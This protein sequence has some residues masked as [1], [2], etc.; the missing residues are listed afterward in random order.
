[1]A[2]RW[3]DSDGQSDGL[4]KKAYRWL[5]VDGQDDGLSAGQMGGSTDGLVT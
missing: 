1:M 4:V 5:D 3:L 2:Y